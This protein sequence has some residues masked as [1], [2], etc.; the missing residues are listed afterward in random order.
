MLVV[1]NVVWD[2]RNS[3]EELFMEVCFALEETRNSSLKARLKG[4]TF[5]LVVSH[6]KTVLHKLF[7]IYLFLQEN[8]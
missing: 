2:Q 6:V 7:V 3:C 5:F 8:F 1:L 4:T